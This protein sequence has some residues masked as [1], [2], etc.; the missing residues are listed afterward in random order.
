MT[1]YDWMLVPVAID[2]G[3]FTDQ[4][5]QAFLILPKTPR[6]YL[7]S[8]SPDRLEFDPPASDSL[9]IALEALNRD[10]PVALRKPPVADNSDPGLT[11]TTSDPDARSG[12]TVASW[13]GAAGR[14]P[15][16][17][18]QPVHHTVV[19]IDV[20]GSG[21]RDDLLQLRMRAD[22]RAIVAE[23]LTRQGLDLSTMHHTDLGDGMRLIVPPEVSPSALLDPF[24]PHLAAA[25]RQHRRASSETAGLRLRVAVHMGL[26]HRDDGGWA[27]APL[28]TC[29]RM[30]D[31]S[32]VR[33][34]LAA[35]NR[36]DLVLVVSET[37]YDGVV[38]HGYGLDPAAFGQVRMVEKETAAPVWI[39]VPG[40]PYPPGL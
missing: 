7:S 36:A 8:P 2:L 21:G 12:V 3:Q 32:P 40:Y 37:V 28:V 1:A 25:L 35:E 15:A 34:V 4:L 39:H 17:H 24:V 6:D 19:A 10:A 5:A 26:L 20:A 29:A 11:A 33:R 9:A 27:G 14:P 18:T 13:P 22:L 16:T 23:V 30:L 38:R 31:A